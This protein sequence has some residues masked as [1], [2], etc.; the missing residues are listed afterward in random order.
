[1]AKSLFPRGTSRAICSTMNEVLEELAIEAQQ[2][3][4]QTEERQLVLNRLVEEML[5]SRPICRPLGT[6]PL[7]QVQEEICEQVR[8]QLLSDLDRELDRYQPE[9]ITARLWSN[10]LRDKAFRQVLDDS[11]LKQIAI[12]IQKLP[13]HSEMRQHLLGELIEA[14]RLSGKLC[15]PHRKKFSPAFYELLYEE[16]VSETLLYVCQNIDKYDPQRGK[17]K[18]FITWVNF[19]LDKLTIECR[20]KFGNFNSSYC[21]SLTEIEAVQSPEPSSF[22]SDLVRE[23]IEEDA[24]NLFSQAQIENQPDANFRAIAL[25]RLS[26][27]SWA[28]ISE[29][30]DIVIPTLSSFYQRCCRKFASKFKLDLQS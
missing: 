2:H 8:Q 29:E 1:M 14:I 30:L 10:S 17:D 24:E 15:R 16:A 18:K 4:P 6:Q 7:C 26:G 21:L 9:R 28:E 23:Y 11:R 12:T 22:F 25:A 13:V 19:H 5:R 3:H 20:R 27:K